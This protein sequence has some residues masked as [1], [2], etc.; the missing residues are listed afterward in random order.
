MSKIQKKL[1]TMLKNQ[2]VE[3][4]FIPNAH[5]DVLPI[6]RELSRNNFS[7]GKKMQRE[8]A[9]KF[10]RLA[11]SDENI[12]NVFMRGIDKACTEIGEKIIKKI[13]DGYFQVKPHAQK[14]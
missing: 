7:K 14:S 2:K 12:S 9:K 4:G 10:M 6:I 13:N 3:E 1:E 5:A 11:N 8:A